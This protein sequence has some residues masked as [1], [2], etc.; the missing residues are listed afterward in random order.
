M[1]RFSST[2]EDVSFDQKARGAIR[3]KLDLFTHEPARFAVRASLA[4]VYL[5]IM[6]AF[7]SATATLLELSAPGW[8]K[9]AFGAIF[10]TTLY[11]IIVLQGELAT[12]DMMFM[13]Y[14]A[15]DRLTTFQRGLALL[16]FVTVFNLVGAVLISA[17]IAHTSIAQAAETELEFLRGLLAAKL[18]KPNATLFI[19]AILAN[20]VVNIAFMLATQA[21]KDFAAK[22]WGVVLIIPAFATMGYEHSVA[23]FVLVALGGFTFS[24]E[25]IAG[26]TALNVLRNWTIVWLGNLVGGGLLIGTVYGWLNLTQ[27][28]YKD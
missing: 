3:N 2:I 17:L 16:V 12:G 5:G 9:Y 23:N 7:A 26:F 10:A 22:L 1:S 20:M 27:T 11:V 15:I 4:G 13:G 19:E 25:T 6:T 8:G 28:Q 21:G 14:G 18:A 24:P